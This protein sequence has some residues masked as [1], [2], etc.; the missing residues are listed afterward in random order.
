MET[1]LLPPSHDLPRLASEFTRDL[2][3][4]FEWLRKRNGCNASHAM[5]M[6]ANDGG[7]VTAR[8]L[9]YFSPAAMALGDVP[10]KGTLHCSGGNAIRHGEDHVVFKEE[11]R[12]SAP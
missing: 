11:V 6:L 9:L 10:R 3:R 5:Q 4:I 2:H 12:T 1:I 7:V 8:R